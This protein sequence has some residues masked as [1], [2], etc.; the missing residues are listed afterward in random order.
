MIRIL[1]TGTTATNDALESALSGEGVKVERLRV[2]RIEPPSDCSALDAA[3]QRGC[4]YDWIV[5]T[6]GNSVRAVAERLRATGVALAAS[7]RVAAIGASTARL[8]REIG[9][10]VHCSPTEA[11]GQA[12]ADALGAF[13]MAGARV[14]LPVGNLARPDV[15]DLLTEMG[16][17]VDDIVVYRTVQAVP[18]A[19]DQVVLLDA[20]RR[21]DIDM[22]TLASPS[23]FEAIRAMLDE[24]PTSLARVHLACIGPTTAASVLQAGLHPALVASEHSARGLARAIREFFA[25]ETKLDDH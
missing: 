14:L 24:D 15:H 12:L 19:P 17:V 23:A 10:P 1:L 7:M 20:L 16:A 11:T 9:V 21:G 6:S 25:Q 22:V 2:V 5:F 3:L 8:L 18:P 4:H 13:E